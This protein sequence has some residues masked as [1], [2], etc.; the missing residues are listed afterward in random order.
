MQVQKNV[1]GDKD[2]IVLHPGSTYLHFGLSVDPTPH[3]IPHLIAYRSKSSADFN[4]GAEKKEALMAS[5]AYQDESLVLKH[6]N[7]IVV[8]GIIRVDLT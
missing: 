4:G 5:L 6:S 2:T 7:N 1:P 8:S 3:S